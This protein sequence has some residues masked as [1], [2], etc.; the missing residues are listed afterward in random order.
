[1]IRLAVILLLAWP[2]AAASAAPKAELWA[3]WTAHDP[4]ATT[5]IDHAAWARFLRNYLVTDRAGL[6][7]VA[8]GDVTG[9]D[10]QALRRYLDSLAT[11][12]VSALARREQLAFWINLYNALTVDVVLAHYPVASIRDIDI[13][14]GLF[15]NGPWGAALITVEGEALSLDDIEHRILRPIWRDP[16]I[17]YG[18]NFAAVGCPNLASTAFTAENAPLLLVEGAA[19]FVNDP[20]GARIAEDGDFVVSEMYDWYEE[21][22][23]DS[24]EGILAHLAQY[25]AEHLQAMLLGRD[26]IDDWEFD[27]RLNDAAV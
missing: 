12:P 5:R 18:V 14:P 20:R 9:E 16:L 4:A 19:I 24:E 10:R 25:A 17:H 3:R 22:F 11:A 6:N 27:W 2:V 15:S 26:E 21:D 13:S 23:G 7:R 8:Y 1:M